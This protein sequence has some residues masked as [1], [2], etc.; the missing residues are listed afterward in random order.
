[1]MKKKRDCLLYLAMMRSHVRIAPSPGS[2]F[3]TLGLLACSPRIEDGDAPQDKSCSWRTRV[4]ANPNP[5]APW[6][7]E[8]A[9]QRSSR[10]HDVYINMTFSK[11][12]AH[13]CLC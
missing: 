12:G 7:L 11:T 4:V 9:F 1:M 6:A 5:N 8:P 3:Q 10:L 2:S 13:Y